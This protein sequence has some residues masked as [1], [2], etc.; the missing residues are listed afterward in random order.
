[1]EMYNIPDAKL[2]VIAVSRDCFIRTLSERRRQAVVAKCLEAK[3]DVVE[4]NTIVENEND[5]QKAVAEAKA[6]GCNS[7]VEVTSVLRLQ[8]P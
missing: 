7:L 2:G 5:A 3:L 8:R 4:I 6:A 1:M